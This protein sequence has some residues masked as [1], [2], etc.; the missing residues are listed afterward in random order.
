M[1]GTRALFA[2]YLVL[3]VGALL[4]FLAVGLLHW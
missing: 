3:I 1:N 2:A 4:Y